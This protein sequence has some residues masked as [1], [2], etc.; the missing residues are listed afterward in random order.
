V[1][2]DGCSETCQCEQDPCDFA[3]SAQDAARVLCLDPSPRSPMYNLELTP[4]YLACVI[5]SG[6]VHLASVVSGLL[7]GATL[8]LSAGS[9][10]SGHSSCGWNVTSRADQ[11][12]ITIRGGG[13]PA[14]LIDCQAFGPVIAGVVTGPTH[15]RLQSLHFT[16]AQ[17]SGGG[18]A[19]LR[20]EHGSRIAIENCHVTHSGRSALVVAD[21][22]VCMC[23]HTNFCAMII[24]CALI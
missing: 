14:V 11:R 24:L 15:L 13:P 1:S 3:I 19:L 9:T 2:G 16:N 5:N 4:D 8:T 21:V 22:Y 20:A 10:Y 18:G 6:Q 7:P 23:V 12:P 17:R